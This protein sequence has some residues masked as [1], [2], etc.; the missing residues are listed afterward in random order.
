MKISGRVL[1]HAVTMH[2]NANYIPFV[3]FVSH[4]R[5]VE[6]FELEIM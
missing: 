3:K 2:K 1:V 4:T 6:A 5:T